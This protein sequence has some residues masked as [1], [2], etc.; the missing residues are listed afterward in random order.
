MAKYQEYSV[1]DLGFIFLTKKEKIAYSQYVTLVELTET[2][3]ELTE[4]VKLQ[5]EILMQLVKKEENKND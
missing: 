5:N 3:A 4:A 1:G 2:V